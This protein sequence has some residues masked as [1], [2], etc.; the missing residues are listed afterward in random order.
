MKSS[1]TFLLLF[2]W[3]TERKAFARLRGMNQVGGGTPNNAAIMV[4][5]SLHVVYSSLA[6]VKVSPM[7]CLSFSIIFLIPWATSL[8]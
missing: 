6:R 3:T 7:V 4:N 1:I 5:I 2:H 8:T